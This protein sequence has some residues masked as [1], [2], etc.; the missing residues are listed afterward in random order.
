MQLLIKYNRKEAFLELLELRKMIYNN[1][2]FQL[3]QHFLRIRENR[4]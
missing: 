3:P 2:R 1:K 4:Y